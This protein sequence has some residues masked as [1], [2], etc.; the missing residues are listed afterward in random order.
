MQELMA[1]AI[2]DLFKKY[3]RPENNHLWNYFLSS[4]HFSRLSSSSNS[5]ASIRDV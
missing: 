5:S 4:S 3:R 2:N 1:E